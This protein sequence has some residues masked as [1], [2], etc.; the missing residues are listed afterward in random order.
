MRHNHTKGTWSAKSFTVVSTQP[1]GQERIIAVT[2]TVDTDSD[3]SEFKEHYSEIEANAKLIAAAPDLLES[4]TDLIW[5]IEKGAMIEEL[6][7][8]INA[9]A[10][11]AIQ[12]ATE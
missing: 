10:K 7:E 8:S 11:Q 5:L 1:L 4:L 3:I 6:H 9:K 2:N 12:K